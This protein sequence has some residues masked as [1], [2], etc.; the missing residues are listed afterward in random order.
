MEP[1]YVVVLV[2]GVANPDRAAVATLVGMGHVLQNHP[3]DLLGVTESHPPR[4]GV[5]VAAE[6][7]IPRAHVARAVL[8]AVG[9]VE[10]DLPQGVGLVHGTALVT[11]HLDAGALGTDV[12]LV[13]GG[14]TDGGVGLVHL[15]N[16]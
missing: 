2:L 14:D 5:V 8:V 1:H 6:G 16:G 9:V 4:Q 3:E 15:S 13:T 7:Q 12:A 11:D 10:P